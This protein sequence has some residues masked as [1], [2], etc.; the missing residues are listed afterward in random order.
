[1]FDPDKPFQPSLLFVGK[2][3]SLPKGGPL[4]NIRLACTLGS[5][6]QIRSTQG[7][8]GKYSPYL[9]RRHFCLD[10]H[11][12]LRQCKYCLNNAY[13]EQQK[14]SKFTTILLVNLVIK[15][16]PNQ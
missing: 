16:K 13:V 4:A 1:M 7:S 5:K 3:K 12:K 15:L 14:V 2:A 10:F 9:W 8:Q 11:D 6:A